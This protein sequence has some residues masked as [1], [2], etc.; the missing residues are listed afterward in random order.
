MFN[1]FRKKII[2]KIGLISLIAMPNFGLMNH[3][4][5]AT[6]LTKI[7]NQSL[8][9]DLNVF[10]F[11]NKDLLKL[12][13]LK[14]D[15][16]LNES[17]KNLLNMPI[18]TY[19]NNLRSYIN[20]LDKLQY[21]FNLYDLD[22]NIKFEDFNEW[23]N[24]EKNKNKFYEIIRLK[25]QYEL[26][27]LKELS[28]NDISHQL[29]DGEN[30]KKLEYSID[31]LNQ[32][33]KNYNKLTLDVYYN[34]FIEFHKDLVNF[35]EILLNEWNNNL[36]VS[37]QIYPI[38]ESSDKADKISQFSKNI[39]SNLNF[40]DYKFKTWFNI[41]TNSNV[42]LELNKLKEKR[43]NF[44]KNNS[45]IIKEILGKIY[46]SKENFLKIYNNSKVQ[47]KLNEFLVNRVKYEF[48]KF[49]YLQNN[50]LNRFSSIINNTRHKDLICEW[51]D[52]MNKI[53]K[54]LLKEPNESCF[55]GNFYYDIFCLMFNEEIY[56]NKDFIFNRNDDLLSNI[57]I[58]FL[59][60]KNEGFI[61][62]TK[63]TE[64]E[65]G[66]E[67]DENITSIIKGTE[68][69]EYTI[70][71]T[72]NEDRELNLIKE[73]GSYL[74]NH[75]ECK[76]LD[77]LEK[78]WSDI[79]SKC[80][81]L[82]D[83]N[84]KLRDELNKT[85]KYSYLVK[86]IYTHIRFLIEL[87]KIKLNKL[88]NFEA[89][90]NS[91]KY[92]D[93]YNDILKKLDLDSKIMKQGCVPIENYFLDVDDIKYIDS[94][95]D[96]LNSVKREELE[97]VKLIVEND[98]NEIF[99]FYDRQNQNNLNINNNFNNNNFNNNNFNNNNFNNNNFNN[100]N[101]DNGMI[102]G[103]TPVMYNYILNK[104]D[105]DMFD[106][107]KNKSA[108][109]N[110]LF[111]ENND[112]FDSNLLNQ[113]ILLDNLDNSS[114]GI[115]KNLNFFNNKLVNDFFNTSSLNMPYK[116]I[117]EL[118]TLDDNYI[119]S[120]GRYKALIKYI[121]NNINIDNKNDFIN[122]CNEN[123]DVKKELNK[124][125]QNRVKFE[126]EKFNSI[127]TNC[128][129]QLQQICMHEN[130][131]TEICSWKAEMKDLY[132]SLSTKFLSADNYYY[133]FGLIFN[134][135]IRNNKGKILN[136]DDDEKNIINIDDRKESIVKVNNESIVKANNEI[137]NKGNI[138]N[139]DIKGDNNNVKKKGRFLNKKRF[140]TGTEVVNNQ[141]NLNNNTGANNNNQN[142]AGANDEEAGGDLD[143]DYFNKY[144]KLFK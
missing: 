92:A 107:N 63:G 72:K 85:Y 59:D 116:C 125:I 137:G 111:L 112:N 84:N 127:L 141:N 90:I 49:N 20:Y 135:D 58:K 97:D 33:N 64:L 82:N 128:N 23:F 11:F 40:I 80:E 31:S 34:I 10:N 131:L 104:V 105:L 45:N 124:L 96:V 134:N 7:N 129:D 38:L 19:I 12:I 52:N 120:L 9:K 142:N 89:E 60:E 113:I 6:D 15:N 37:F 87:I 57:E 25:I 93:A 54:E 110:N 73:Y 122:L 136:N 144:F 76:F 98:K 22:F 103:Y 114:M 83:L 36:D 51:A 81:N 123:E 17:I 18:K 75:D 139:N 44:L 140:S 126:L 138:L 50:M 117:V 115:I 42:E 2:F 21:N 74:Q 79:K 1:S 119:K 130:I 86:N 16:K 26:N 143:F 41:P 61:S 100:N 32:Y 132:E 27:K 55:E 66:T 102:D 71:T 4:I 35:Y 39:M 30:S 133:I 109:S 88:N 48:D 106:L 43:L 78:K 91:Y 101:F 53:R 65:K 3:R 5:F 8:Y 62:I 46:T 14:N 70:S 24:S 77:E 118:T 47:S 99:N 68:L 108:S 29:I 56:P 28:N 94:I 121:L 67:L 95:F 69:D 13:T